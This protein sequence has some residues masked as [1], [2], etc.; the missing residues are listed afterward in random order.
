MDVSDMSREDLIKYYFQMGLK[1]RDIIRALNLYHGIDISERHLKRL[2]K[3][4]HLSRRKHY[5]AVNDIITFIDNQLRFS[6]KQHG[7][8]WMWYKCMVAGLK[9]T[10]EEVRL[11]LHHLDPRGTEQRRARRLLRRTY[12]SKGPNYIWHIDS[13]D[14]IK[15]YGFCING[16]IDGYSRAII[17][18]NCYTTSNDPAVIGGYF[19]QAVISEGGCPLLVR[20]DLGTE[21]IRVKE[22]QRFC[23]RNGVD[24][25]AGANSF[26]EGPST[27]NQRI[28]YLW[29]FLRRECTDYWIL[30]FRDI[31]AE[32]YF[33][34]SFLDISLLQFCFMHLVQ[35]CIL[36]LRL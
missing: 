5:S 22:Y 19:M 16:C 17:W 3:G 31:E 30:F 27:A 11:V 9:C 33:D 36:V 32:G 15:R 1:Y 12:I 6:G 13:Y 14:K 23:R 26:L 4:Q 21:N 24:N 18:L 28:E 7:Y 34:G 25:R 29:N 35:V 2:L 20:C 10:K 8:R